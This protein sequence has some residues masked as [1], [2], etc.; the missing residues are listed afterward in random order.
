MPI[1]PKRFVLIKQSL[2]G[3][4][5]IGEVEVIS[6][7]VNVALHK[8]VQNSGANTYIL[9]T[10]KTPSLSQTHTISTGKLYH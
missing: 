2:P 5:A 9:D 7:G 1:L 6:N 8:S 4:L 3:V 10:S